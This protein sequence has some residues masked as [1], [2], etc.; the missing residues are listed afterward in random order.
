MIKF[1]KANKNY[2]IALAI[3]FVFVSLSETTYSLFIK[4]DTTNEFNYNTGLLD[5]SFTEDEPIILE[6]AFL[7]A[8][9]NSIPVATIE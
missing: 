6:N 1:I 2:V 9:S 5:L 7:P 4:Q 8:S 3:L